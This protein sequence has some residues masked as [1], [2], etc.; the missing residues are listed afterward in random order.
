MFRYGRNGSMIKIQR[1]ELF[2]GEMVVFAV[3]YQS[4]QDEKTGGEQSEHD[5]KEG[6]DF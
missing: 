4:R 6:N 1:K 2:C 5:S 3:F